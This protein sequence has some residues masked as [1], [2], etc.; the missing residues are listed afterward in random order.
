[1]SKS[2]HVVFAFKLQA[3][4][5]IDAPVPEVF[6]WLTKHTQLGAHYKKKTTPSKVAT[7]YSR[8]PIFFKLVRVDYDKDRG[9]LQV[10]E[11]EF[12]GHEVKSGDRATERIVHNAE[13]YAESIVGSAEEE[14]YLAGKENYQLFIV[15]DRRFYP[16]ELKNSAL[17]MIDLCHFNLSL[18]KLF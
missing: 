13:E 3:D 9:R 10:S 15:Y 11:G 1:M 7:R 12:P 6:E 8:G 14:N 2:L 5:S 17:E 16:V 18:V 4:G